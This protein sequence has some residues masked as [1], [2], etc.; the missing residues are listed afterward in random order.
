MATLTSKYSLV[1]QAKRIDPDGKLATIAEVL[2]REMG[3]ILEEAPWLMS[4]DIWT[5]KTVRRG[6]LPAGAWRKLNQGVPTE[7]ARTTEVLDVIGM[8]ET[9]AEYDK[10]FIDSM[11]NP[12][13]ARLQAINVGLASRDLDDHLAKPL[14]ML[15]GRGVFAVGLVDSACEAVNALE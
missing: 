1:E 3:M 10:D 5:H 13:T 11:P 2:N 8:L 6:S 12:A 4:N 15:L 9:Y 7:V 14:Q